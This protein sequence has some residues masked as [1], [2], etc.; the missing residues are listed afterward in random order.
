MSVVRLPWAA[1]FGDET[2]ELPVPDGWRVSTPAFGGEAPMP[3]RLPAPLGTPPLRDLARG[4]R[5]PVIVVDDL[6]RPTPAAAIVPLVLAELEA[7]GVPRDRVR[8]LCGIAGHRP[9]ARPELLKKLG[10][11]ADDL[12]VLNHT[13]YEN[14]VHVG[15]TTAGTPVA[16]NRF[17]AEADLRI[18]VGCCEPHPA[19]GM[20]G[21]AKLV[22]PG[23]ASAET[24]IANHR[25]NHLARG[26]LAPGENAMRRDVEEAVSMV[27]LDAIV[28][29]VVGPRREV[30]AIFV[31]DYVEAHRAAA[32]WAERH[33][34]TPV[35][36]PADVAIFNAYPK[37]TELLQLNNALNCA[38]AART[39]ILREGGLAVITTAASEG[40][41]FHAIFGPGMRLYERPSHRFLAGRPVV[42]FCPHGRAADLPPSMPPN[43]ILHRAWDDVVREVER[44]AG[45]TPSVTVF[46][47]GP[48]QIP[49]RSSS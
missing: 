47:H 16:I 3:L 27:G 11:L 2:L 45:P 9:L 24:I 35:E 42:V 33:Y 8:V 15:T 6:T 20:S 46:T 39:P 49:E 43:T 4:K 17:Y 14:L 10:P 37:D 19:L 21:G 34:A 40:P 25:P 41:G 29:V 12:E 38:L 31:G 28:N 7:G 1:W 44:H 32:A 48:L 36:G 30:A 22:V 23:L 13:P 18:A 5:R 26:I